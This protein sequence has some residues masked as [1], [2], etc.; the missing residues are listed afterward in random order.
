M[1]PR[2]SDS[3]HDNSHHYRGAWFKWIGSLLLPCVHTTASVSFAHVW[4]RVS[5]SFSF[6]QWSAHMHEGRSR[7]LKCTYRH[8]VILPCS[9][10]PYTPYSQAELRAVPRMV[11][12]DRLGLEVDGEI[13]VRSIRCDLSFRPPPSVVGRSVTVGAS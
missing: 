12:P 4:Y 13:P 8:L 2:Y 11:H 5:C 7:Y 10:T 6:K 1:E 9:C 3:I